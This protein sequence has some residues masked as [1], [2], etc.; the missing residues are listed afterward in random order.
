MRAAVIYGPRKVVVTDVETPKPS[1]GWA[2]VKV[3][4]AGICGTD[5][6]FYTGSYKLFKSPLIP[7]HEVVGIVV[8]GP[9]NIVGKRVVSEI[10]FPCWKCEY[11]RSGLYTHCPYKKTLGI[12]FDGGIAEY[13]IAPVEALHIFDDSPEKGIFVEPLAAVLR[14]FSL[15]SPRPVDRVAVVGTGTVAWLTVQVL[16]NVYGLDVDV[17]A[18]RGSKKAERFRGVANI[19]YED[20]ARDSQYDVVFEVSGDPR[21]LDTAI[22]VSKPMATIHLKSTPGS[23]ASANLTYGVV[24]E[25]SIVTSRCGTFKEFEYAAKLLAEGIVKPV[26]DKIYSLEDAVKAFED[27][28]TGSFFKVALKP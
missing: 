7:G 2:L 28:V 27:A 21:A 12:D 15:R 14:A 19:V 17:I 18:R 16:R 23:A 24:K 4:L 13:F 11:C 10:N 20:E 3:E 22:R 26:L 25:V 8:D 5:K 6:A 1:S 9:E